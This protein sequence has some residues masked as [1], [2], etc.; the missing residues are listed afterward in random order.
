MNEI[1]EK[2]SLA[3]GITLIKIKNELIA[4]KALPGQFVVIRLKEESERIPLTL[5]DYD[6]QRGIINIVFQIVGKSTKELDLLKEGDT[7]MDVVGPLGKPTEIEKFGTVVCI[8]G[9]VGTPEIYPVARGLR[10]SGN[11]V[12][13]II[14]ARSRDL[15]IMEEEM[16]AVS[17]ELHVTTDDG[18][19]GRKG[20]V[21]DALK[22]LIDKGKKIDRVFAV[23][24]VV[25][26]RAVSETTRPYKIKTLVSLNPIMLDGTGMCGV[27]RVEV[28]GETKFACVDGPE[29]DGHLV[30]Y[31]LLLKRL[32][33]Y[34]KQ[35][36]ESMELFERSCKGG[37]HG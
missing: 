13:S 16:K 37:C 6:P 22:E 31:D 7:I 14:G 3:Q 5:Q 25:M 18:S 20:F 30:N 12:V 29:F 9:G 4:R 32:N 23:G 27:C 17:D 28:G 35:E 26:M 2:K 15:L 24:P 34:L 33:T 1:L 36:K 21:T 11:Y 8:G 19:Y 10:E